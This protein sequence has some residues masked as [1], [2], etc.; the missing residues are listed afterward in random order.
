M[1]T[2]R[3]TGAHGATLTISLQD[4]WVQTEHEGQTVLLA[5]DALSPAFD[6]SLLIRWVEGPVLDDAAWH[7]QTLEM[8]RRGVP[9]FQLIDEHLA[10]G[11]SR[12]S[13]LC[14]GNGGLS[15]IIHHLQLST[16]GTGA[17]LTLSTL[18]L[19]DST[20]SAAVDEVLES[21]RLSVQEDR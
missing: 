8:H 13:F 17:A 12:Q 19:T 7:A 10:P 18:P 16:H 3:F 2:H 5:S 14:T 21:A 4:G 20:Q 9:D 15:L 6:D 11:R 1:D